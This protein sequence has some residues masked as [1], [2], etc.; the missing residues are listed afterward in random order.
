LR[1]ELGGMPSHTNQHYISTG[2]FL[3]GFLFNRRLPSLSPVFPRPGLFIVCGDRELSGA[4][5]HVA[6]RILV[7]RQYPAKEG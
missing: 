7:I 6:E 3:G 4:A 5:V 2:P 1:W